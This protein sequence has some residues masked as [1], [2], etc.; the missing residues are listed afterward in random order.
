M[1]HVAYNP[2][3]C[4]PLL[5]CAA[6]LMDLP[7]LDNGDV[8]SLD[9]YPLSPILETL[10]GP[11]SLTCPSGGTVNQSLNE[12]NDL[13]SECCGIAN[14]EEIPME[15]T[16]SD[17][18]GSDSSSASVNVESRL[19][20]HSA[21]LD[22]MEL[23]SRA[24]RSLL[25][26]K[27]SPKSPLELNEAPVC[28]PLLPRV[29]SS[30]QLAIGSGRLMTTKQSQEKFV[31]TICDTSSESDAEEKLKP[32][33][34][35][36]KSKPAHAEEELK[37]GHA[38]TS[39]N[40]VSSTTHQDV[41]PKIERQ[42]PTFRSKESDFFE[43]QMLQQ[44]MVLLR[45]RLT[46]KRQ[47]RIVDERRQLVRKLALTL[48]EL[49][50]RM[51]NV[52][53]LHRQASKSL[54]HAQRLHIAHQ[55]K[56]AANQKSYSVLCEK[57]LRMERLHVK[58]DL[59]SLSTEASK[60]DVFVSS[61]DS[62]MQ[63]KALV[64]SS[65][66]TLQR[67]RTTTAY[68]TY[69]RFEGPLTN[70]SRTEVLTNALSNSTLK[71]HGE[72]NKVTVLKNQVIFQNRLNPTVPLCPFLL[73]GECK[74]NNCLYQHPS[75]LL[76]SNHNLSTQCE[77]SE[78]HIL[79]LGSE[80]GWDF[81]NR[82]GISPE[83]EMF[84]E[85]CKES[86]LCSHEVHTSE[87]L[88]K[89]HSAYLTFKRSTSRSSALKM[90]LHESQLIVKENID[91]VSVGEHHLAIICLE[92][93]AH[94]SPEILECLK[95]FNFPL[96]A[97]RFVLRHSCLTVRVRLAI[98]QST[99]EYLGSQLKKIPCDV[100][101]PLG[102]SFVCIVYHYCRLLLETENSTRLANFLD[103]QLSALPKE[104]PCRIGV[105]WIKLSLELNKVLPPESAFLTSANL[106]S[107]PRIETIENME[108]LREAFTD[109]KIPDRTFD[110]VR[111]LSNL[112]DPLLYSLFAMLYM[113]VHSLLVTQQYQEA[114]RFSW[115]VATYPEVESVDDLFFPLA[116]YASFH[117]DSSVD[118]TT[119][120]SQYPKLVTSDRY[121][122][123]RIEFGFLLANLTWR[124][125]MLLTAREALV[126][127]LAS[128]V[129]LP[130]ADDSD[131]LCGFQRLILLSDL[132][133]N[134]SKQEVHSVNGPRG[135]TYLW[136]SYCLFCLICANQLSETINQLIRHCKN[137]LKGSTPTIFDM[138]FHRL[139]LHMTVVL[140]NKFHTSDGSSY[141]EL[142]AGTLCDSVLPFDRV[143]PHAWFIELLQR[144]QLA[145]LPSPG[146][147]HDL[148]VTLIETYGPLLVPSLCRSL[149]ALG[150]HFLARVLCSIARLDKPDSEAF[151]LLFGSLMMNEPTTSDLS[152]KNC[153]L[154]SLIELFTEATT[155]VPSSASLWRQYMQIMAIGGLDMEPLRRRAEEL[156]VNVV[157]AELDPDQ[158]KSRTVSDKSSM[159][160]GRTVYSEQSLT[161]SSI[162]LVTSSQ[163]RIFPKR[164]TVA[165][166]VFKKIRR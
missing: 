105:W 58:E 124:R 62:L 95:L 65:L 146:A 120:L 38:E 28:N 52:S 32:T 11:V 165:S 76:S 70:N 142:I 163:K 17:D 98:A 91:N 139:L 43:R 132:D 78:L 166:Q 125:G 123:Y 61:E 71:S 115:T 112:E 90:F 96:S 131:V 147:R 101:R 20:N 79:P 57:L 92:N 130:S 55:K 119:V 21:E 6:E 133:D 116:V 141:H 97:C 47:Q 13:L 19:N 159:T 152:Q 16:T 83:T 158:C 60:R 41:E 31:I 75:C 3:D 144:V 68:F 134:R 94:C 148:C 107:L 153:Y 85:F 162:P 93:P 46:V 33:H 25:L 108:L 151:W 86:L 50:K 8:D 77:Q 87:G 37:S 49:R 35:E 81:Q 4:L 143:L 102:G 67:A 129:L 118:W 54:I 136:L 26:K 39:A 42:R 45:Q 63:R 73:D 1:E 100:R 64:L 53:S 10:F 80:S 59:P 72:S 5:S 113:Y 122:S 27:H 9:D 82:P 155:I 24:L 36:K 40:F 44:K 160:K 150:D 48:N 23:R 145:L 121:V 127:S 89:W 109:L 161:W 110:L 154:S 111:T 103:E 137:F 164:S 12:S 18:G 114:A 74:D 149:L 30:K 69:Y 117:A 106:P 22:E 156:G 56:L 88:R 15:L 138:S 99:I 51:K 135:K 29:Q 126:E 66:D 34:A 7:T 157:L 2:E 84:C 104:H 140:I 14:L 128:V